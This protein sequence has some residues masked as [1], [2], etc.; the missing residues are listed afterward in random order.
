MGPFKSKFLE[1]VRAGLT[2]KTGRW[3]VES[4]GLSLRVTQPAAFAGLCAPQCPSLTAWLL[5]Q[6]S[7]QGQHAQ[8][9]GHECYRWLSILLL[10]VS[11][12]VSCSDLYIRLLEILLTGIC[13]YVWS[14]LDS[15]SGPAMLMSSNWHVGNSARTCLPCDPCKT[16]QSHLAAS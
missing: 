10:D 15:V 4:P 12:C 11:E 5:L 7:P 16:Q 9:H 8:I 1:W 2:E 14:T 13:S 6:T 3:L